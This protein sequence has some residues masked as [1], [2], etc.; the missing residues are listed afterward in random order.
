MAQGRFGWGEIGGEDWT[1]VYEGVN[2]RDVYECSHTADK[3]M[4]FESTD[5]MGELVEQCHQENC[6]FFINMTAPELDAMVLVDPRDGNGI[7]WSRGSLGETDF[8]RLYDEFADE[9]MV[10]R[11]KFPMQHVAGIILQMLEVDIQ[12]IDHVPDD[13][14]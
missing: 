10:I 13:W 6:T 9:V 1:P 8:N 5:E 4:W 7:W 11:T 14:S 2:W 12:S 3:P